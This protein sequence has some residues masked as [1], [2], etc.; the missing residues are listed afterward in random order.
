M[1]YD[2]IAKHEMAVR[3]IS[4]YLYGNCLPCTNVHR[5]SVIIWAKY[6]SH[7]TLSLYSAKLYIY[8]SNKPAQI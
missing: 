6:G 4:S 7:F 2:R 3:F 1:K 5:S 8:V